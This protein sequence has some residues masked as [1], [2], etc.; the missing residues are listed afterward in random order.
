MGGVK[1]FPSQPGILILATKKHCE[2]LGL[3]SSWLLGEWGRE[4]VSKAIRQ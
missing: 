3:F 1:Y 4:V 2:V